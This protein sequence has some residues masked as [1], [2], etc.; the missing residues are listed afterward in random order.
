VKS[1]FGWKGHDRF[2]DNAIWHPNSRQIAY[3]WFNGDTLELR[4]TNLEGTDMRVVSSGKKSEVLWPA[5]WSKDGKYILGTL[6]RVIQE[7]PRK[8]DHDIALLK[9]ADGSIKLIKSQDGRKC[10]FYKLA[11]D[12]SY[13]LCDFQ[14]NSD[15]GARDIIKIDTETGAETRMI[16]H[17]AD[18]SAPFL[19]PDGDYLVFLSDRTG[20]RGLWGLKIEDSNPVGEPTLLKG[21]LGNSFFPNTLTA[22]GSLIYSIWMQAFNV[23]TAMLDFKS[24]KVI[25]PPEVFAKRFEGKNFMPSWSPDGKRIAFTHYLRSGGDIFAM[26]N[27]LPIE[28]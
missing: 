23:K 26:E 28:K 21:D 7:K 16:Y 14:Q 19:S 1:W 2:P 3:Y 24:G 18:D 25:S 6:L 12:N 5:E 22:D 8:V 27:F 9:V 10:K 20:L 4:I 11:P 15:D 13:V 17:P